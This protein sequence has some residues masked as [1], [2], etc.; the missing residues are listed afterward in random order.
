MDFL[1]ILNKTSKDNLLL[2]YSND[3]LLSIN[4]TKN[5]SI[6]ITGETGSGKSI[7]LDQIILELVEN[8]SSFEMNLVL[9]DTSGVELNYYKDLNHTLLTAIND[10]EKSEVILAKILREI[11]RRKDLLRINN[12]KNVEEYNKNSTSKLPF[13]VIAIDDDKLLLRYPDMEKMLSGIISQ[14]SGLNMMFI[15]A[16]SD[17]YNDF[18]ETD[19]NTLATTLISF[20]YSNKNEAINANIQGAENLS[21]G[22]F[23]L[24]QNNVL[25]EYHNFKFDDKY[26]I[27]LINK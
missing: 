21:I 6:I 5:S 7:L 11:S 17:V 25:K 27:E 15:L 12:F 22:S 10:I 18:F 26:I 2:G 13:L 24:K 8:Y 16:T 4:P 1:S 20:D 23:L 14:I 19:F 3:E 9:I